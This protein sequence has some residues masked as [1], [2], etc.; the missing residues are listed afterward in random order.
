[1]FLR[2][3]PAILSAILLA[4]HFS[5]HGT[6]LLAVIV[7]LLPLV[8]L[9]RRPWVP[10]FMQVVLAL[11]ALEWVRTGIVLGRERLA[12]GEPWARMAVI[13]VVVAGVTALSAL[14][15]RARTVRD[16]YQGA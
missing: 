8:L 11:A 12:R 13:L 5:R 3:L 9:A 4:A 15:F 1:M 6:L 14:V 2:L 7:L 16:H 10:R